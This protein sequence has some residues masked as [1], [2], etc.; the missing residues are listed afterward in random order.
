LGKLTE[1]SEAIESPPALALTVA[2]MSQVDLETGQLQRALERVR[3]AIASLR[4]RGPVARLT[5]GVLGVNLALH[6]RDGALAREWTQEALHVVQM[7]GWYVVCASRHEQIAE[8]CCFALEQGVLPEVAREFIRRQQLVPPAGSDPRKWPWPVK[9][10]ALGP[11]R[12]VIS[13]RDHHLPRGK[14]RE[15]FCALLA[16]G[17]RDVPVTRLEDALWPESDGDRARRAFDTTLH[18][19]RQLLPTPDL[20][21]LKDQRLSLSPRVCWLDLWTDA[22]GLRARS[23]RPNDSLE[24]ELLASEPDTPWLLAARTR[25]RSTSYRADEQ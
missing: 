14:A 10:H 16:S 13:E 22:S 12:L 7:S 2:I 17:G 18:R 11:L 15:L 25:L 4:G 8:L 23:G 1:F 24:T 5:L 21:Q 20:L 3:R 19:L 6:L 9:I